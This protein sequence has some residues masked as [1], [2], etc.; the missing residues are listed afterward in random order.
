MPS[1]FSISS[2]RSLMKYAISSAICR[3]SNDRSLND[4]VSKHNVLNVGGERW[5]IFSLISS[6][7]KDLM[8]YRELRE[9]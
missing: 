6:Y 4:F 1:L 9:H 5:E 3:L 2:H 8:L 7:Y